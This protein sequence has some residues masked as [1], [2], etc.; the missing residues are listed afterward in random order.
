MTKRPR[1]ELEKGSFL[2]ASPDMEEG[3]FFRSVVLICEHSYSGSFGLVINKPLHAELPEEIL[4][5]DTINNTSLQLR[6]AGPIQPGQMMLLHSS[7]QVPD[8]TMEVCPGVHLGGDLEFL[9]ESAKTSDGPNLY[10]CF[11]YTGW[12]P[13]LLEQEYL[14]GSWFLAPAS[15]EEVF[16]TPADTLWRNLL[17]SMGGKYS[18]LSMIPENLD[19]N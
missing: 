15:T 8:Q 18:S 5:T 3:L 17:S 12:G 7:D 4:G 2:V 11:G 10:L 9:Q 19:L 14:S 1:A 16:N 6:A 13:G